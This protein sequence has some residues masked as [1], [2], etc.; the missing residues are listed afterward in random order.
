[1]RNIIFSLI[2]SVF[3][4]CSCSACSDEL[5][6][7]HMSDPQ[8]G[9]LDDSEN[10]R[11]SDSLLRKAVASINEL[12]PSFVIVTG[13]MLNNW[14]N[15]QQ[16]E[17]FRADMSLI[18]PSIPVYY[19][20]GNHDIPEFNDEIVSNYNDLI[21][22]L[23][24]S[25]VKG[26]CAFIGFDSCCIKYGSP[27]DEE[28]QFN[29]LKSELEKAYGKRHIF[30]FFH[31]PIALNQIDEEESYN[32]FSLPLRTKY[33]DLFKEYGVEA[34]FTGHTHTGMESELDGIRSYNAGPVS[35]AFNNL[36]S[37]F[38][39]VKVTADSVSVCFNVLK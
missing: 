37:G 10:F 17:I 25:F 1:M 12:K 2:I 6:F 18:D 13:D 35:K 38:N 7:V 34:M 9:F 39:I 14:N 24:F 27:E 28:E 3:V 30:V 31:C 11:D 33:L 16:K 4:F 22:Y 36:E 32:S 29:W 23:R 20:P 26:E 15:C 21:G 19:T 5:T 8:I